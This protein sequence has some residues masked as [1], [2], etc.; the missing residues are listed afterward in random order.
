MAAERLGRVLPDARFRMLV[1]MSERVLDRRLGD[2]LSSVRERCRMLDSGQLTSARRH[3][4]RARK[5]AQSSRPVQWLA[6]VATSPVAGL[7]VVA[8]GLLMLLVPIKTTR[9]AEESATPVVRAI[10]ALTLVG[11]VVLTIVYGVT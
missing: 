3:E 9:A 7:V 8:A 4:G 11:G 10:G 6:V 5:A 2:G 1:G